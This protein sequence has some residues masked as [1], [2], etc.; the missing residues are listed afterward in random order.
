[1]I[2]SGSRFGA[3]FLK[4]SPKQSRLPQTTSLSFGSRH[5]KDG[6]LADGL[7]PLNKLEKPISEHYARYQVMKTPAMEVLQIIWSPGQ[8]S[9][10]HTHDGSSAFITVE[11]GE[12]E[13]TLFSPDGTPQTRVFK[14]GESVFVPANTLHKARNNAPSVLRT[15]DIYVPPLQKPGLKY[16]NPSKTEEFT[17]LA[18]EKGRV[19]IGLPPKRSH[20]R[21]PKKS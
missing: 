9:S 8:E 21:K 19:E 2:V 14:A 12:M 5:K 11:E 15:L 20:H 16:D 17:T 3:P 7:T 10:T 13:H 1:M 6:P 18:Q 4:V